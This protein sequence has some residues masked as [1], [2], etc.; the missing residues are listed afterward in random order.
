MAGDSKA[1][2]KEGID[3]ADQC[4]GFSVKMM[5]DQVTSKV[6]SPS[7]TSLVPSNVNAT[8]ETLYVASS[9]AF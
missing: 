3:Y 1:V 8:E 7:D 9:E 6:P 2:C 4:I 5:L